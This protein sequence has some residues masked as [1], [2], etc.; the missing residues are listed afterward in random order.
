MKNLLLIID[1]QYDFVANDGL[2][3]VGEL[4]QN[5]ENNICDL[6]SLY[7]KNNDDIIFTLDT[8]IKENWTNHPESKSFNIH[9]IKDSK[10]HFPY[11]KTKDILNYKNTYILEKSAYFP[12]IDDI[13]KIVNNYDSIELCGVVTDI[14]VLQTAIALYNVSANMNKQILFKV[15]SKACASFDKDKHKFAMEYMK[16][17][18]G[19][20]IL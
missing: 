3:T 12:L 4:A 1:Y 5:I 13:N 16:K 19:F 20:S 6:A 9:C 8:H 10:G 7:I 11:G 17:I 18:L 14:C 2:L 15:N